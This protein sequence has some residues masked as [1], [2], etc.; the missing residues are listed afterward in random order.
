MGIFLGSLSGMDSMTMPVFRLSASEVFLCNVLANCVAEAR[1]KAARPF[2]EELGYEKG[3]SLA[4][5]NG[6]SSVI[7]H[8]LMDAFGA[9][10]LPTYWVRTH[11]ENFR[12][13]SVYLKELDRVA[14]R[15]AGESIQLVV[16]KNGGIAR[17]I[18][19]C[20]GCCPMGDLDVLV[21]KRHFQRAHKSLIEDG[22]QFE[23][24]SPLEEAELE[25]AEKGGGA[26]YWKML[27]GGEKLWLEVQWRPVAGRWIRLDQEPTAEEFMARSL[28]ISG[29]AV[30]LLSPEDN[31]LQ[32]TLHTA[33]HSYVR[34][35]GFRLHLDVERIVRAYPDLDWD[36]FTQ[37]VLT[38]HV[39][40]AV[41]FSLAIPKILFKTPIP[42]NVLECLKPPQW[43]V[44]I[45]TKW[46]QK[47]GLFNP[48]EKKFS[49][50]GYIIFTAFLYDDLKGLLRRIFPDL[51]WMRE[52][53][54]I[55]NV[56]KLPYYYIRH[57]L[58]LM[59]RRVRT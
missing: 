17:G 48:D 26:E 31:L 51:N 34:A 18:Y 16:L 15:L 52:R 3:F 2:I 35:P 56:L 1:E 32:V 50:I 22:Y 43:K 58:D 7:A 13:I 36:I 47:A 46:L 33:K 21:E 55:H 59:L 12:R 14:E 57:V 25:A 6:I 11:E 53:Y 8:V 40:T 54:N 4:Q 45:I 23:F 19:P 9:E 37:N 10:N 44:K 30:R 24:R 27:P 42:D 38:S 5:K 20:P 49:R 41:Y 39:K 28:P 29:T